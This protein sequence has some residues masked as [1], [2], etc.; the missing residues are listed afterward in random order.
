MLET[1]LEDLATL[2]DDLP[3]ARGLVD[4]VPAGALLRLALTEALHVV[5][6]AGGETTMRSASRHGISPDSDTVHLCRE[7]PYPL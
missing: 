3:A 2:H 7:Y 4:R 5:L 6:G 1:R